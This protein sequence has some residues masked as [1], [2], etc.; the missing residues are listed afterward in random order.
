MFLLSIITT[1]A[2]REDKNRSNSVI[3]LPQN[4]LKYFSEA[5]NI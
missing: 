2:V 1:D 4:K 5:P 3:Y